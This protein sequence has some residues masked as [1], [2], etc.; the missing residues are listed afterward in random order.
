MR[1]DSQPTSIHMQMKTGPAPSAG[2]R[3][4]EGMGR[5]LLP[6]AFV[7]ETLQPSHSFAGG[8]RDP[9]APKLS[10]SGPP[11]EEP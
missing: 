10:H 4:P 9:G 2:H 5:V 1:N 6:A 7:S 3:R 8:N 11:L